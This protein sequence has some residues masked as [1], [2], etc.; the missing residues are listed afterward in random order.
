MSQYNKLKN[1]FDAKV[2]ALQ[3]RCRHKESKWVLEWWAIGHSTGFEVR[4]CQNCGK[5]LGHRKK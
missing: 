4:M 5:I 1:E 3:G 2:L